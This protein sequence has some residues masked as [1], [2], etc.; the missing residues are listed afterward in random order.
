MIDKQKLLHTTERF[1][2]HIDD[3]LE[4]YQDGRYYGI[5]KDHDAPFVTQHGRSLLLIESDDGIR[6]RLSKNSFVK[7]FMV[8]WDD[9]T[10]Q[11]FERLEMPKLH[12][13]RG[14]PATLFLAGKAPGESRSF[15]LAVPLREDRIS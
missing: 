9:G 14:R 13:E 4:W 11:K 7:D 8:R 1:N 15:L 2:F 6:W 10:A 12:L 5:V 3:H